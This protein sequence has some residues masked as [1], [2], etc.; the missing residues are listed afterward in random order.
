M[1]QEHIA[2]LTPDAAARTATRSRFFVVVAALLLAFVLGGFA[3]TFFLRPFFD[4]LPV[5]FYVYLHGAVV[6]TWFVLVVVQTFLVAANRT[7]VHRRLGVAAAVVAVAL[8]I[9]S[10]NAVLRF[11]FRLATENVEGETA[12]FSGQGIVVWLDLVALALFTAFVA[13]ALYWRKHADTHK[14]LMLLASIAIIGP[15]TAR[16]IANRRV[17]RATAIGVALLFVA[18]VAGIAIA[19]TPLGSAFITALE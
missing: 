18:T 9:S 17:H 11:P 8:V 10:L 19:L 7:H 4:V 15:A 5:P 1:S 2:V 12:D 6:T 13:A 3:R 16:L 14:R